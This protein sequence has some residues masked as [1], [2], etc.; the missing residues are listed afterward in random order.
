MGAWTKAFESN[1]GRLLLFTQA[2]S[3]KAGFRPL[4]DRS[5]DREIQRMSFQVRKTP[6][7]RHKLNREELP[8]IFKD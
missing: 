2:L 4:S 6:P 7:A 8:R 1:P 5:C 3:Q